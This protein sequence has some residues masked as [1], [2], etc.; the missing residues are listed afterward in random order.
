M[1]TRVVTG[2]TIEISHGELPP[3]C[4]ELRTRI[5]VDEQGVSEREEFDGL[6]PECVHFLAR[7]AEGVVGCARLRP[8]G[9]ARAKVERVAVPAELRKGG[10]GRSLMDA[11][12]AEALRQGWSELTLYGQLQAVGFYHRLG[13][14]VVGEEFEEA[15]IVHLEMVKHAGSG[16]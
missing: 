12:E 11:V 4:A 10:F 6:D 15:G 8:L 9:G 5:F 2:P 13:W 16:F 3:E 1:Y 14:E 7:G